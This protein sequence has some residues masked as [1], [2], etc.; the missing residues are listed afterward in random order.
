MKINHKS[1]HCDVIVNDIDK[2]TS[3]MTST[4]RHDRKACIC[5]W[6]RRDWRDSLK[7]KILEKQRLSRVNCIACVLISY[8]AS[9]Q[10]QMPLIHTRI[11][12]IR[13]N[14]CYHP[15]LYT[16]IIMMKIK[17]ILFLLP[18]CIIIKPFLLPLSLLPLTNIVKS[19]T[20]SR[21]F[22]W[23]WLS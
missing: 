2:R 3:L 12:N 9:Y 17:G 23:W 4:L 1:N 11:H 13:T 5:T 18:L 19:W 20:G 21:L 15:L 6:C 7:R 14:F 10:Q 22:L 16:T 8:L